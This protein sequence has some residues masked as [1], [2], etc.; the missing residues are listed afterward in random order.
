M[1]RRFLT[2]ISPTKATL[3]IKMN[4]R[5]AYAFLGWNQGGKTFMMIVKAQIFALGIL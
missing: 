4:S 1:A 5:N 2:I 3:S